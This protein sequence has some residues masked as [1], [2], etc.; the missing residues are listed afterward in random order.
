MELLYQLSYVGVNCHQII[1][2][3]PR[4]VNRRGFRTI[5]SFLFDH[6]V[7]FGNPSSLAV[8]KFDFIPT[9]IFFSSGNKEKHLAWLDLSDFREIGEVK[10]GEVFLLV[11][12]TEE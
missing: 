7:L 8:G 2:I 4:R 11:S 1:N 5:L 9:A 3:K 12:T 10:P 6:R